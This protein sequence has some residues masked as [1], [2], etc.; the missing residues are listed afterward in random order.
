MRPQS[1]IFFIALALTWTSQAKAHIYAL[2]SQYNQFEILGVAD[3]TTS[4]TFSAFYSADITLTSEHSPYPYEN[5]LSSGYNIFAFVGNGRMD[6]CGS[7]ASDAHCGRGLMY[8]P[9]ADVYGF[10]TGI[11]PIF[12]YGGGVETRGPDVSVNSFSIFVDLPD[13]YSL[14]F[15][16][17]VSAVPEPSTWA[18][19]LIGFAGLGVAAYRR[20]QLLQTKPVAA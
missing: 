16:Q 18:M 8:G 1:L 20:S 14:R 5:P 7:N 2:P 13:T 17:A 15:P 9:S 6:G 11:P 19:L 12:V 10:N 4:F 3:T